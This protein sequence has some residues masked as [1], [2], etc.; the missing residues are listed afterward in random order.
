M[1]RY[2]QDLNDLFS[3][4]KQLPAMSNRKKSIT[5]G[6]VSLMLIF[7]VII[8]LTPLIISGRWDWWEAWLLT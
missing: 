1:N 2:F 6:A 7:I 5:A 8:P 4:D 3:I